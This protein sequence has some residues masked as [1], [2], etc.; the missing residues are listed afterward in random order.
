MAR[1]YREFLNRGSGVRISPGLPLPRFSVLNYLSSGCSVVP[2]ACASPK[3]YRPDFVWLQSKNC[4][5]V[6][7]PER[8]GDFSG[9]KKVCA[10]AAV[11][12]TDSH[13]T[14]CVPHQ[15]QDLFRQPSANRIDDANRRCAGMKPTG[16][17]AP[18]WGKPVASPARL[19]QESRGFDPHDNMICNPGAD[20]AS[21]PH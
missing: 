19:Y 16:R 9:R 17:I 12:D 21:E 7:V 15:P 6:E 10:P 5:N 2:A 13:E 18:A 1:R 20:H 8:P 11:S 4:R 14:R 3:V